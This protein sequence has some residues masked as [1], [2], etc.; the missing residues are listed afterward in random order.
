M[1]PR[2]L[3]SLVPTLAL[4]AA[5]VAAAQT[6]APAP[7]APATPKDDPVVL[8]PFSVSTAKD[9]GYLANDTLAGSRLRT[10]LADVPN[11][12]S[13]FTPEFISDLNAFGEADLMRYSAA[14]VPERTDQTPAAQGI[15][16]D[17]GGF[18]FRIRGQQASRSRNY[19]GSALVPDTYNADR[20]EEAR[21]PNA[22]LFGLG[23]AGGI[24]N[25]ST[26]TARTTRTFTTV[27]LTTDNVGL[28]RGTLDHNQTLGPRAALRLNA[29]V[30][31]TDGWQE[32]SFA[33]GRRLHLAGTW[34]P[35]EKVTLRAEI[36][37]GHVKNSLT[38]FYAPFDNVSLWRTG[39]SPVVGGLAAANAALGI[40][41][42]AATARLTFVGNDNTVRNFAQTVFSQPA[43]SRVNS[44]VLPGDWAA[45]E[46]RAPF[47]QTAS[48]SGP[49]G[50]SEYKQKLF[51]AVLEAE[52]F[53]NV[54]VEFAAVNDLRDHD[55]YDTTHDVYR[56]LGEPGN[57]FRD[58]TP[59][60]YAGLYYTDTRW[61]LRRARD[62]GERFRLTASYRLDLGKF[63]RH[64]FS[65]LAGRD[66]SGNPRYV[67]FLV[68]DGSPF[69][70]QPQNAANQLW[71]RRYITNPADSSQFAAPD[72]RRVPRTFTAVVDPGTPARTFTT[73]WAYNERNDQWG[74]GETRLLALQSYF[75]GDRLVTTAGW[76]Y[77]E[78]INY[79]RPTNSP[80]SQVATRPDSFGELRFLGAAPP[81]SPYD[82]ERR[83]VGV[84]AKATKWLS[85]YC[86]YS[87]NAQPPGTTQT[88]IP[89]S[90]PF[91]LNAGQGRDAGLMVSLFGG[92][93]FL[94]AG[95]FSTTSVDQSAAFGVN[96]VS[97]RH[98][99]IMDAQIAAGLVNAATVPRFTGGDFDLSDLATDGYEI[100][101]TG[102]VTPAWRVIVNLARTESVQTNMLKRSRA[103]AARVVPLWQNPAAQ[104]LPTTA[105]VTVAQEI[106]N[107]QNWLAATTAVENTGTVG[108][109]ELEA[110]AFTRYDFTSGR[111]KGAFLGGGLSYGSAPV[112]GRST[113]GTLFQ[114]AVRREADA[115][116]GYRTRLPQ[117]LGRAGVELQLNA[118]NLLQQK[119][120]TLVRRDPDG[121]LFR[122][123]VNPPTSYAL[124][125]RL[126]F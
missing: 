11:A 62:S 105:G 69:N 12:I 67:G 93:A 35:W 114:A 43:A 104:N 78:V 26:K 9:V 28:L 61:V 33:E 24:L 66:N 109:R 84:V 25:T 82:F 8:T 111:L 94:R 81:A 56:I 6:P 23:G 106:I 46:S 57:T 122:A 80:N 39:G 37:Y 30:H 68:A 73:A 49:G 115:L 99:R 63:G 20:F 34:R 5:A 40:G 112:I 44:V 77:T 58:G 10:N 2:V 116:L 102:N 38:R 42:R 53:K 55:V 113:T 51:G 45:F 22:I 29:V 1:T 59:N 14:A 17:T 125:A 83:S 88:L 60:P 123:A 79:A 64:N 21:G 87:E 119:D 120:Y 124:S 70:A 52:P 48:F 4:V 50:T 107:Y 101:L 118:N 117:W 72:F 47:P 3:R 54:F 110:R 75:F 100:N 91:P 16:I 103:A 97:V 85:A 19:F 86:N 36:E 121:Q 76:R 32:D 90:S 31:H 95:W 15:S 41:K 108:H 71:T 126:N 27:G 7:T 92:R 96:N 13:V 65:G 89:D 18:Q 98:D 74:R